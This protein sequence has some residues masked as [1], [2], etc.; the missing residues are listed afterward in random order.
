MVSRLKLK[1]IRLIEDVFPSQRTLYCAKRRKRY[2]KH[3]APLNVVLESQLFGGK[4]IA[5]LDRQHPRDLYDIKHLL[6]SG[7]IN[8]ELK[9]GFIFL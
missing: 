6:L 4:I 2:L 9:T 7:G 5:A 1:S 3:S 8:D